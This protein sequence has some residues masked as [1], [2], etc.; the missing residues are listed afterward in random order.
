MVELVAVND[1]I[2]FDVNLVLLKASGLLMSSQALR[3][4]RTVTE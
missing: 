2:R 1:A 3:L 4:A